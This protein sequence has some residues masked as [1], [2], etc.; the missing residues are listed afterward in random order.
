MA[1]YFE[2]V[3]IGEELPPLVKHITSVGMVMYAAA[4]WDYHR[5]H[6]DTDYVNRLG[7][8]RPFLDGQEEGAFLAQLVVDWAG[9]DATLKRLSFRYTGFVFEGDVLTCKGT[10]VDKRVEN[11][12]HLVECQLWIDNQDGQRVLDQGRAIVAFPSREGAK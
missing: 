12:E 10:V 2:D 4:T 11:G 5:Y 1:R 8:P 7:F 6:H 3:Q 9:V